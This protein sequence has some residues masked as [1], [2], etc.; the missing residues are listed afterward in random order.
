MYYYISGDLIL[1]E[2]NMAVVE[3]GGI[4]YQISISATTLSAIASRIGSKVTLFTHLAVREDAME[5]YG[6]SSQDEISAFRML[7]SVS[8]VGAKSAISVL[9]HLSPDKFALAV[10]TGDTKSISKA[11]GIGA[12]TAARIV[13]ELKDK[14][15]KEIT[16]ASDDD[17]IA[18]EGPSR[19]GG[20]MGEAL[21]A[22]LVLGYTRQE[23][24]AAL[25]G[26][27]AAL[28]LE[29]MIREAL[30]KLMKG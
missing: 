20:N 18:A 29:D 21:N 26:I 5:L 24:L 25:K 6:F 16:P 12:K 9:S 30:K 14:I 8:G 11:Q 28:G 22:L 10:A 17:V 4:G 3:A 7:I 19:S 27:D 1:T 2:P 13:L 23:A 15:A